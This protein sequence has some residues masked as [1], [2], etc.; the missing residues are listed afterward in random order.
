MGYYEKE[1]I[2]SSHYHA[3]DVFVNYNF[4]PIC[5]DKVDNANGH[6]IQ[7]NDYFEANKNQNVGFL[8]L[9]LPILLYTLYYFA[10]KLWIFSFLQ[11][12]N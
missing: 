12:S 11:W 6:Q 1:H 4:F 10:I 8:G 2:D 7:S 3:T 5:L 9:E